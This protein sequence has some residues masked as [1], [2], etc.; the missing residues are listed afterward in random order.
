M[1]NIQIRLLAATKLG[2]F[3]LL[4]KKQV[5]KVL[6]RFSIMFLSSSV[7]VLVL[8]ITF[9]NSLAK[10]STGKEDWTLFAPVQS[11]ED[12]IPFEPTGEDYVLSQSAVENY[13]DTSGSELISPLGGPDPTTMLQLLR[14]NSSRAFHSLIKFLRCGARFDFKRQCRHRIGLRISSKPQK[15]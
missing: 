6:G 12:Y 4:N 8:C 9:A 3:S 2:R 10:A 7:H 14:L 1:I 15:N 11:T 5:L 13:P